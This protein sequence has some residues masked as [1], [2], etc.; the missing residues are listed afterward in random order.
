MRL[1]VSTAF[2]PG[3]A[4]S[5]GFAALK[6]QP[7]GL[8]VGAFLLG[9]PNGG[10]GGG[11]GGNSSSNFGGG[12]MSEEEMMALAA[13]V[14]VVAGIGCCLGFAFWLFRSWLQPGYFRLHR[15]LFVQGTASMGPL[16]SGGDAFKRM[17]LWKLLK[18]M[19]MTTTVVMTALPGGAITA[20][21][22]AVEREQLAFIG[23]GV[24]AVLIFP[25]TLYVG[26]GLSLGDHAV[27]LDDAGPMDAM[28]TSWGLASGSRF[29]L[30]FYYIATGFFSMLGI[31]ACCV[32]VFATTAIVDA[33][34]TEAY[35]LATRDDWEEALKLTDELGGA[36]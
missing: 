5:H 26:L 9:V 2:S 24:M 22:L 28:R 30:L 27:A 10:G 18:G 32:G 36:Y 16:F 21:A 33:G 7:V 20:A 29:A 3:R 12:S 4:V 19:I 17:A 8:L 34:T 14:L 23:M 11:G 13:I 35:L 6:R 25:V 15:E 1:P 31:L